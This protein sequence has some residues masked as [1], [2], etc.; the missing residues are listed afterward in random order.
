MYNFFKKVIDYWQNWCWTK[1]INYSRV[2]LTVCTQ[3]YARRS[4]IFFTWLISSS[5]CITN[6]Y[7]RSVFIFFV[8][9]ILYSRVAPVSGSSKFCSCLY[10]VLSD[11]GFHFFNLTL[12]N[13]IFWLSSWSVQLLFLCLLHFQLIASPT[14]LPI[15]ESV[16]Y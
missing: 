6:L 15:L 13:N 16:E 10:A 12:L 3:Y 7:T 9:A 5:L 1:L 11:P 4:S 8:C 2:F 14:L